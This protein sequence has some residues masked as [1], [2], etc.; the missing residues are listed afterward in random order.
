MTELKSIIEIIGVRDSGNF[1]QER[2]LLKAKQNIDIGNFLVLTG[3]LADDKSV[4]PDRNDVYWFPDTT[5]AEGEFIRLY[6]KSGTN[7]KVAGK[8]GN[9]PATYHNFYWDKTSPVWTEKHNAAILLTLQEWV[10]HKNV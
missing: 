7:G 9:N 1:D 5:V 8:Y 2:L 10:M 4:I 3:M 6:S